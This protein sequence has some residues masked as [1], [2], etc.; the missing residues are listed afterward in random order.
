MNMY[1]LNMYYKDI[2]GQF[3]FTLIL[4]TNDIIHLTVK[5]LKTNLELHVYIL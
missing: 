4:S 5:C 3:I 2:S 1:G